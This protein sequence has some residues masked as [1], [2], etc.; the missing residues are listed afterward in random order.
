MSYPTDLSPDEQELAQTHLRELAEKFTADGILRNRQWREVFQRTWRHPY[1]PSF[2]PALDAPCLLSIDPQR[3][4]EWLAAVYSDQT[5][6]TKVVQV[7]L[8]PAL[9]PGTYPVYTSSSTMPSLVLRMLEALDVRDGHRVLEIGTGTGYHAALL[10]ERLGSQHV[11]SVDIDPELVDLARERLAANGY[12]PTLAVV[13][14]AGG[15]PPDA[16]YDRIIATCAVPAIPPAWL[17][18]AAPGAVILADVHGPLGGTLVRL[19]VDSDG[20]AIGRFLPDWAGFM[21]LRH[22][23]GVPA[24]EPPLWCDDESVESDS[25]VDPALV[26]TDGLFGFVAQWHLPDV[27]WGPAIQDGQPAVHLWAPDGSRA[28]VRTTRTR[29]TFPVSQTG[30]RRLWDRIE[31][32]HAFWHRAGRP[33]Y[34]QFGLTATP[35]EQYV[36]YDHPDSDHRWPLRP[37]IVTA[38]TERFL[39]EAA[40]AW[41]DAE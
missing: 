2:Y 21:W 3:R 14:G 26:S 41:P 23:P 16:P 24:T 10:C 33:R 7:P 9:R 6:I 40:A 15:Y 36:W 32:A 34:E 35:T 22:T 4:G 19:A 29:G 17:A 37:D 1:V 38:G 5:L 30:P 12:A 31:A 28:A 20:T 39:A 27:I 13:D 11:T 18:Q 25:E 8:S